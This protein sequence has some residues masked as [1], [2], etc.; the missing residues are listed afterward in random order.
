MK[1]L[2]LTLHN[3]TT[4][5]GKAAKEWKAAMN[6]LAILYAERFTDARVYNDH[7]LSHRTA[8]PRP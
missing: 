3:I 2:W 6:Q 8:R 7:R 1:L 4:D 5:W